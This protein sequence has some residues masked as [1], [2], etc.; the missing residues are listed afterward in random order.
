MLV[1]GKRA[2]G[3]FGSIDVFDLDD[4]SFRLFTLEMLN[5]QG[6]VTALRDSVV[7][8]DSLLY[9]VK[10]AAKKRVLKT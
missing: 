7:D 5:R 10:Q 6:L 2:D 4:Q 9:H 8:G 1:R 3:T